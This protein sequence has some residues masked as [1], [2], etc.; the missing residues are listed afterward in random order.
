MWYPGKT[1]LRGGYVSGNF[2]DDD[3]IGYGSFAFGF[4]AKATR[5]YAV[6]LGN[7][8]YATGIS[9]FSVGGR[10]SGNTSFAFG[11]SRARGD[12]SIAMGYSSEANGA[13][14][15]AAGRDAVA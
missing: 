5:Q 2:W 13:Y 4:N 9:S 14:S 8:A 1:A 10:A 6:A 11:N 3:S 7:N 15:F 12:Y